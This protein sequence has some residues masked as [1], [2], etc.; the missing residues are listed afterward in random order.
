MYF[1]NTGDEVHI[2]SKLSSLNDSKLT[3][4]LG[5]SIPTH[6]GLPSSCQ[7]FL[8]KNQVKKTIAALQILFLSLSLWAYFQHFSESL[9]VYSKS[10]Q[11]VL[12]FIESG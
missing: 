7:G 12:L 4:L 11:S 6:L 8:E 9:Y 3:C 10:H 1:I 2:L 5:H